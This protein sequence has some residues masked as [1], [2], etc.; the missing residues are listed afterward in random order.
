M[1]FRAATLAD[2]TALYPQL[3]RR[4]WRCAA[5]QITAGPAW[6][7][8]HEGR[9]VAVCGLYPLH[10]GI[11]EAWF[12]LARRVPPVALRHLLDRTATI[13]PD[14]IIIA[15]VDDGNRAGQR[16]AL[17]SGFVPVDEWLEGTRIR[18]W[19]RPAVPGA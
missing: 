14:R 17:L 8:W 10:S 12:M 5:V 15:R 2:Y 19:V 11:L 18:T 6:T 1:E 16:L 9:A 4:T 3:G 7:L 13:L